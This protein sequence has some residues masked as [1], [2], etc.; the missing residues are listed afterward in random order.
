M[1]HPGQMSEE[2]LDGQELEEVDDAWLDA[3]D[4]EVWEEEDTDVLEGE[5]ARG[6]VI[7]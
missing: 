6:S 5:R 2:R 4:W 1:V 7:A 3:P